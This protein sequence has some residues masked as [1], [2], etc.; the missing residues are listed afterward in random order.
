MYV[1]YKTC[2]VYSKVRF[3]ELRNVVTYAP[4]IFIFDDLRKKWT[5]VTIEPDIPDNN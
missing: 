3:K 1:Y 5:S 2:L 4:F